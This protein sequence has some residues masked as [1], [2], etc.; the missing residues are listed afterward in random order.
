MT[1][2]HSYE[3]HDSGANCTCLPEYIQHANDQC[4]P[5]SAYLIDQQPRM[6]V[7]LCR[8]NKDERSLEV[9]IVVYGKTPL[10]VRLLRNQ[11]K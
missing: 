3:S 9:P 11:E 8:A 5:R 2:Y 4:L 1:P 7:D 10:D 6:V